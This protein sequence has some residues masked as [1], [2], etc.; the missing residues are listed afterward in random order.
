MV[1]RFCLLFIVVM[2]MAACGS[3]IQVEEGQATSLPP[4]GAAATA[5]A[6]EVRQ[7]EGAD[8]WYPADP[9]KLRA[10]VEA[11]V[12]GAKPEPLS[13][14]VVAVIVPHAG[15]VYSGG[16]AGYAY[17]ALQAAGCAG[18]TIAVIGDTHSGNGSG[19]IAVWAAGAFETP[20]GT[21]AVDTEAAQALLEGSDLIE[22]NRIA[23]RAEHPVENQIPFIQVAC[24]G[25]RILPIVIRQPTLKNAQVLADAL[26]K[27]FGGEP[28][29]I[30]ASTDLSHYYPYDQARQIDQV[31]LQA[32]ASL[33]PR[34]VAD[35][36]Q[37]CAELGIAGEPPTMCSQGAVM[38][39]MIAARHMGA[40]QAT[41]LYHA[42]SG[43]V[44]IGDRGQ[45]VGYGAV[46]LWQSES[47]AALAASFELPPLPVSPAGPLTV[48]EQ[49]QDELLALARQTA[50]QYLTSETFP[51]FQSDNPEL[52]QP[53]GAFVTLTY[54]ENGELRGC[55]GRLEADRPLYLNVQ[56]AAVAAALGDPR[57]PA[58]T[59]EELA[60]LEIEITVLY[61]QQEIEDPAEIQIGRHGVVLQLDTDKGALFLP[62]VAPT[63]GWDVNA[64]LAN[65]CRKAGIS[66]DNCW[67]SPK[68]RLYVFTGQWFGEEE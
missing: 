55:I 38:T 63:E 56:Y 48:S 49:G 30:V 27:A 67:Q 20:L 10:A 22:F 33:D 12:N 45:V 21:I 44:P 60:K 51:T 15:Y 23:F 31:A 13:G 59:A 36:S 35:S 57:F 14:Q 24:P 8:K 41:V 68:A 1:K 32:I 47:G 46:A 26:V 9:S 50:L 62:Q 37:R 7:A 61:P 64:T 5:S 65:L 66:D 3:P 19:E 58:V 53:L 17:R 40:N 4:T 42:T 29:L 39:A 2:A 54:K 52:A 25:A 28:A 6:E 34:A 43:D 16:V 18:Q 11:F